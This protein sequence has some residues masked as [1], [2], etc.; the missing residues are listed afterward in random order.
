MLATL[1]TLKVDYSFL[2]GSS[3]GD[4][5]GAFRNSEGKVLFQFKKEVKVNLAVQ[6]E[7]LAFREG[8][9]MAIVSY[10]VSSHSFVF[11]FDSKSIVAWIKNP[12]SALCQF[13]NA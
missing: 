9:L 11:E 7:L 12:L 10:W 13:H 3:K 5:G 1:P 2:G 8:I 6:T 4:I